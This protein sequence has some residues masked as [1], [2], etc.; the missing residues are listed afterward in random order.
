MYA[1]LKQCPDVR[2]AEDISA[3]EIR[4]VMDQGPDLDG[5]ATRLKT[6]R[7]ALKRRI[8]DLGLEVEVS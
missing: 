6:P 1:L 4:G 7:E 8:C 3:Q 5:W 2:S